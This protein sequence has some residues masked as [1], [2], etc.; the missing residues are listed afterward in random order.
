MNYLSP[1]A[2]S[3]IFTAV[4]FALFC[5]GNLAER[6]WRARRGRPFPERVTLHNG[7]AG[8]LLAILH[9][10]VTVVSPVLT[11]MKTNFGGENT[12]SQAVLVSI[13]MTFMLVDAGAMALAGDRDRSRWFHHLL[14]F[15][16]SAGALFSGVSA[17][18]ALYCAAI[19]EAS[20]C[21]Y[22]RGFV[23]SLGGRGGPWDRRAILGF[24]IVFLFAR[25]LLM[26]AL[27]LLVL[28]S[29]ETLPLIKAVGVG[30]TGLGFYWS[31]GVYFSGARSQWQDAPPAS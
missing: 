11:G 24:T 27:L 30:L 17:A 9:A 10:L 7:T 13:L 6:A 12:P 31:W 1:W 4:W 25:V 8:S 16:G 5:F 28:R 2:L 21:F 22:V 26:P 19:A 3:L 15:V 20:L 18:E 14:G 23:V 29:Q